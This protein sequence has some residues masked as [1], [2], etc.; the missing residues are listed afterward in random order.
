MAVTQCTLHVYDRELELERVPDWYG[1]AGVALEL[2]EKVVHE[3]QS[4]TQDQ[5]VEH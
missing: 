1:Y 5:E 3:H 4:R 2:P